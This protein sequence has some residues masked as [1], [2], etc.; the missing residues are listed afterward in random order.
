MIRALHTAATG[1][2]SQQLNIDNTSNNIANVNTTAFKMHRMEFADLMYQQ[3]TYAG[4]TTSGDA[5][6]PTGLEIGLGVR[7][8]GTATINLQG[9]LKETGND[10]DMAISGRGFFQIQLPDGRTGY[11]RD[12]SF[13]KQN[14]GTI[15]DSNGY[16]LIPQIQI[17]EGST[18]LT[19]GRDGTISTTPAGANASQEI[20]QVELV[21][22]I[23]V[24]GM[25]SLGDNILVET[26]ASG[27]PTAIDG[28]FIEIRQR[29]LEESN[30]KLVQEMTNLI[31]AQ[32]AYEANSKSIQAADEMLK[33]VNGLKR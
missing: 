31:S 8:V 1:M 12:G 4:S 33:T 32:R 17:P 23:N 25:H 20:G 22:F 28:A 29:F 13:H 24:A 3:L 10:L 15:V 21:D 19:I 11:T 9:N 7:A 26:G 30:V 6:H 5:I 27:G 2:T 14:D 16:P 18:Q